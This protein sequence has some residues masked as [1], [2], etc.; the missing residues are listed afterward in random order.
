[1]TPP[2][3]AG[4]PPAPL[5][6]P[7]PEIRSA[8][9]PSIFVEP[10]APRRAPPAPLPPA[11]P[12]L[13]VVGPVSTAPGLVSGVD[14]SFPVET[15]AAGAAH[16]PSSGKD[17]HSLVRV[18]SFIGGLSGEEWLPL[19]RAVTPRDRFTYRVSSHRRRS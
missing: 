16:A 7:V 8:A 2:V 15:S 1:M 3:P 6:P 14:A 19:R 4:A 17:K 11:D 13:P 10:P 9:P 5:L 12:P 18:V